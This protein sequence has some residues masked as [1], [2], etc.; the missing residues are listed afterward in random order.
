[1]ESTSPACVIDHEEMSECLDLMALPPGPE[2]QRCAVALADGARG[3]SPRAALRAWFAAALGDGVP[4]AAARAA[5]LLAGG[6]SR[7][8]GQLLAASPVREFLEAVRAHLPAPPP[9]ELPAAMPC[10]PLGAWRPAR[11]V[12]GEPVPGA[13]G[14]EP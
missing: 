4:L 7:W 3:G 6:A 2:R 9:P 11:T 13:E 10:P 14:G 5:F 8:T 1:M 12:A